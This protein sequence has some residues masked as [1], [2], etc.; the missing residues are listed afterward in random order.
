MGGMLP[1]GNANEV[2]VLRSP[3]PDFVLSTM[4]ERLDVRLGNP[5]AMF[6]WGFAM[7]LRGISIREYR[8]PSRLHSMAGSQ[9]VYSRW[10]TDSFAVSCGAR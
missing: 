9:Q 7:L 1:T 10:C 4:T 6:A 5:T 2:P 3:I 8:H